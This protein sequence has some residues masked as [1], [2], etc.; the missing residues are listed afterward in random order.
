MW[1]FMTILGDALRIATFQP[2]EAARA[3]PQWRPAEP[4]RSLHAWDTRPTLPQCGR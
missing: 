4:D 1:E 2:R 3:G